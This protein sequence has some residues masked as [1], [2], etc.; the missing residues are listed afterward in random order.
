MARAHKGYAHN[1]SV[2]V[3][4]SKRE[5]ERLLTQHGAQGYQTGWQHAIGDDPG[6]DV[7]GFMWKN[8]QVRF[9]LDRPNPKKFSQT[10][11]DQ[12]NR[13]RWRVLCLV[14]K[15]KLEAVHAGV[16]I[17]EQEFLA[18]IVTADD[19]TVGEILVPRLAAMG[20]GRLALHAGEGNAV[21]GTVVP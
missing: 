7:I 16:S 21:A 14:I 18:N 15:A 6:W 11:I 19:R 10:A 12:L 5:I 2:P 13:S 1:T 4:K 9:R 20:T 8:R 17:F 3:E